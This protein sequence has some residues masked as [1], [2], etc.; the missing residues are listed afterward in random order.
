MKLGKQSI[1]KLHLVGYLLR[2]PGRGTNVANRILTPYPSN[3]LV[4]GIIGTLP[5]TVQLPAVL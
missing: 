5:K 2:F 3:P 4:L 1:E